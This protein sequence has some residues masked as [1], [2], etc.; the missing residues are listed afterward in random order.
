[1]QDVAEDGDLE[2]FEMPLVLLDR[3][4]VQEPLRRMRVGAVTGVDDDRAHDARGVL[5][6]ALCLVAHDDGIDAHRLDR[7]ERIA[8]ALALDDA[9]GTRRD[10]DDVRAEVLAGELERRARARARL[11]EQRDNGFAA[12]RR[13]LLDV[14][15]DDVLHFLGRLEH[16]T[17]LLRREVSE[18]EDVLAP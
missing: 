14:T 15:M 1:M 18:S 2:A 11:V 16:E 10:V 3:E 7:V 13:D 12:Q 8:Q 9:R 17:D 6:R 5:R 4:E